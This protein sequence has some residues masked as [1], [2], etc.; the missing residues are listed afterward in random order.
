MS[1]ESCSSN[2]LHS[3][4]YIP[5][6]FPWL[7]YWDTVREKQ[8][9]TGIRRWT[10][11]SGSSDTNNNN[12]RNIDEVT[13][14]SDRHDGADDDFIDEAVTILVPNDSI[15]DRLKRT[16]KRINDKAKKSRKMNRRMKR[17]LINS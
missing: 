9:I 14:A 15:V 1:T 11:S 13:I 7:H 6:P 4:Y 8:R 5:P 16:I 2:M 17:K 12:N 10:V 3:S